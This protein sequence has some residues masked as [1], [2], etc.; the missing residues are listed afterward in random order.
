MFAISRDSNITENSQTLRLEPKGVISF[1]INKFVYRGII[2]TYKGGLCKVVYGI[3][4][5]GVAS[6]QGSM[7]LQAH[8]EHINQ[9]SQGSAPFSKEIAV[10]VLSECMH[11]Y[12][13][14]A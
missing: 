11:L 4:E 8:A 3:P 6:M 9:R 12:H 14:H 1:R 13:V 10:H 5:L 7:Q 2:I